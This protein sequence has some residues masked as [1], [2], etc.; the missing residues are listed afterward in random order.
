M[1][2]PELI[3]ILRYFLLK[4]IKEMVIYRFGMPALSLKELGLKELHSALED[5]EKKENIK[6][7]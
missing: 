3:R 2:Y 1:T 7:K 6:K 5:L 4:A